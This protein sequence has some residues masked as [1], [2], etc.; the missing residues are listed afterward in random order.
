MQCDGAMDL[1][2]HGPASKLSHM[3]DALARYNL[4]CVA[5]KRAFAPKCVFIF[6]RIE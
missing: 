6:L 5:V 2:L 3:Q 4:V 1:H